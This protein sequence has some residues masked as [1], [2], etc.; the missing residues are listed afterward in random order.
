M[1]QMTDVTKIYDS[2]S[3]TAL[4]LVRGLSGWN[5]A[6]ADWDSTSTAGTSAKRPMKKAA[7]KESGCTNSSAGR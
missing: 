1:V 6:G 2:S 4:A 7:A 3:T 5:W